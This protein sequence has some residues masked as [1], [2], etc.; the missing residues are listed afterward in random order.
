[1]TPLTLMA[2][3]GAAIVG[4]DHRGVAEILGRPDWRD[5]EPEFERRYGGF[6]ESDLYP[7]ARR[8]L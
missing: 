5:F 7:D 3:L 2:A 1:M 6:Q 8:A 4:G